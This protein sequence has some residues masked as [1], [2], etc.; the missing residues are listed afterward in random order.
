MKMEVKVPILGELK[1]IVSTHK[2]GPLLKATYYKTSCTH[3]PIS[4]QNSKLSQSACVCSKGVKM[5]TPATLE[6]GACEGV[7]GLT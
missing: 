5:N 6:L 1:L 3:I 7:D 4:K 2:H